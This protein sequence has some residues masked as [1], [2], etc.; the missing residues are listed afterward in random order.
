MPTVYIWYPDKNNPYGH[1]SLQTDKYH[2]SFWPDGD[3]K[4]DYDLAMAAILGIPGAL[5]FDQELDRSLEENQ[6]PTAMYE[7]YNSTDG[8]INRIHEE[9]LRY[10]GIDPEDVTLEAAEE[11]VNERE[12]PKKSVRKTRYT[13]VADIRGQL[14]PFDYMFPVSIFTHLIMVGSPLPPWYHC[15]QSCVSFCY[16]MIENADPK[17]QGIE[18]KLVDFVTLQSFDN[19]TVPWLESHIKKHWGKLIRE[20][21][22]DDFDALSR[23][24]TDAA[25]RVVDNSVTRTGRYWLWDRWNSNN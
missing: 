12:K 25:F 20:P 13:F 4:Q 24:I 14:T 23:V 21:P 2:I 3:V 11:L 17:P 9:F 5:V 16:H 7:L 15:K 22:K 10:N 19:F 18:G 1:A 6:L 8:A